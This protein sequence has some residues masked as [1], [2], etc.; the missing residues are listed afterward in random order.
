[1][2]PEC[3]ITLLSSFRLLQQP[4]FH[5]ISPSLAHS[6][7]FSLPF[8][9][10]SQLSSISE[11]IFRHSCCLDERDEKR[12]KYGI[13]TI[14]KCGHGK[15]AIVIFVFFDLSLLLLRFPPLKLYTSYCHLTIN[16]NK[17][18]PIQS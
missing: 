12:C 6:Q 1:M 4:F 17:G 18:H 16:E 11:Q 3:G 8:P 14:H 5:T 13:M 10:P 15:L 9:F 7:C 2:N